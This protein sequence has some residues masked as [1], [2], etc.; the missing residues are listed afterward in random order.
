[1]AGDTVGFI[2]LGAMGAEMA[3]RLLAKGTRVRGFDVRAEAVAQLAARGGIASASPSE[4]A[5]GAAVLVLMVATAAQVE[6][7]LAGGAEAALAPGTAVILHSTVPPSFAAALGARLEAAGHPFLDAP[8]SGGQVG[9]RTGRLTIMASG[10][11]AA[12]RAAEAILAAYSQKVWRL[13]EAAGAGSTVKLINQHL[14]GV[15]LAA[16]A[17]AMALAARAG[18]DPRLAFEVIKT[19]AGRSWMLE[20]RVPHM[21]ARDFTPLSAV[22]IFIKDLGIV[23][24]AGRERRFPLPLAAAAHQQFLAA[25]AAGLGAEDDAAVVK[26]YEKLAG[27]EVK[28]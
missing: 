2:G 11:A 23:L 17:E 15:H 16:A 27:I 26:V 25:A 7:V 1:M 19:S 14:A 4:A 13:G 18:I 28:G 22:E 3:R 9:A 5:T 6:A 12:F 8:V 21:L 24:D 10:S 20:N